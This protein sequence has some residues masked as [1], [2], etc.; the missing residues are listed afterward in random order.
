MLFRSPVEKNLSERASELLELRA[1]ARVN[2]DY[3][4][5]DRLR[6]ELQ[7][8]GVNVRDTAEGQFWDIK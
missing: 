6:D 7:E 5:S 8:L 2:K 3:V 4:S 1:K